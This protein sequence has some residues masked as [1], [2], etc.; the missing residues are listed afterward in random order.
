MNQ[1]F[2]EFER[3]CIPVGLLEFNVG[4]NTIWIQSPEGGT[5]L[6]I[7]RT[8]KINVDVCQNSPISHSDILVSGD[9]EFC[10]SND[11]NGYN[12]NTETK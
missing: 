12:E 6:R 9:I 10:L 4:S 5:T 1:Q 3:V 8:G 2:E 7:K 11:A